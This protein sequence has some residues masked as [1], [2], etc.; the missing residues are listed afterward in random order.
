MEAYCLIKTPVACQPDYTIY[1]E[2]WEQKIWTHADVYKWT[3]RVA[4]EFAQ[5]H[6]MLNMIAG[7]PFY[8]LVDNPKLAKFVT[9]LGYKLLTDVTCIDN[10]QR[11]IYK[12]G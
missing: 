9:Q 12:Y 10:I 11:S 3:P 7:Q 6:G 4:K 2:Y 5:V 8:C 1:Y